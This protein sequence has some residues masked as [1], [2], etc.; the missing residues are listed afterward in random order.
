MGSLAVS[1]RRLTKSG[2]EASVSGRV[3]EER[4]RFVEG[5]DW[6]GRGSVSSVVVIIV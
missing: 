2:A 3:I 1:E 5:V 4:R 6:V